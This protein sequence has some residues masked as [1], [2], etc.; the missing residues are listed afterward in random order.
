MKTW[1]KALLGVALSLLCLFTTV[2]YADLTTTLTVVGEAEAAPPEALFISAIVPQSASDGASVTINYF[3]NTV[4][5]SRV[6]LGPNG[7]NTVTY[8]ITVFN[9]TDV[10]YGYNAMIYTVGEGTFDNSNIKVVPD[11][12]H[13]DSVPAHTSRSFN[14]TVSYKNTSSISNTVLNSVI[15]YEF[16][17]MTDIPESDDE[18]AVGGVLN[19]FANILNNRVEGQGDTYGVLDTQMKNNTENDR[20]GENGK[21]YI[22]NVTDASQADKDTLDK[23]FAG[24]LSLNINGEEMPVTIL[25]K[26]QNVD[27]QAGNEM[28]IYMTTDDLVKNNWLA[29]EYAPVYLA[30]FKQV[31][32]NDGVQE[33]IQQGDMYAGE[34]RI[35]TYN[36]GIWGNGSFNTDTWRTAESRTYT[37]TSQYSYTVSNSVN[38]ATIM[39]AVDTNAQTEL[40][41]L[42][43]KAN[44]ILADGRY[45]GQALLDLADSLE[46]YQ[47]YYTYTNGQVTVS[48]TATRAQLVPIIRE[49]DGILSQIKPIT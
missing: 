15:I 44:D 12:Q 32:R 35:T 42:I 23:L 37:V 24:Q 22:G 29:T 47:N 1:T 38:L 3:T 26:S 21:T 10:E 27:G 20:I 8:R 9:N 7:Q 4:V 16:L 25:I 33:W 11:I 18:T 48:A 46:T 19:Q 40:T 39:Q 43:Q 45:S 17:P 49:L 5:N 2:G 41:R 34:A 30:V 28:V 14:V 13:R 31:T 36:G 6:D